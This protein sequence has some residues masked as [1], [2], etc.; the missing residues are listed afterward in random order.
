MNRNGASLGMVAPGLGSESI[1]LF[2]ANQGFVD[3]FVDKF[4]GTSVYS[5]VRVDG[6]LS[7]GL[8]GSAYAGLNADLHLNQIIVD[9]FTGYGIEFNN[10]NEFG[11]V[12]LTGSYFG[13]PPHA[14]VVA[15]IRINSNSGMLVL[16]H[17]QVICWPNTRAGFNAFGIYATSSQMINATNNKLLGCAR[18]E[19]YVGV[20]LS[21]FV[22]LMYNP[23]GYPPTQ[24]PTFLSNSN[25]NIVRPAMTGATAS[26]PSGIFL[27]SGSVFNEV[28]PTKVNPGAY[29]GKLNYNGTIT[30]SPTF[31]TGNVQTGVL[32]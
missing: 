20:D 4:E 21:E 10:I 25:R 14:S 6:G 9:L 5:G 3:T 2:L 27:N 32:N 17:N 29:A 1:A 22:N 23:A 30:T 15:G 31:G 18:P 28:N 8:T 12:R 13:M 19:T 16:E 26:F 24:Q 11:A 7:G